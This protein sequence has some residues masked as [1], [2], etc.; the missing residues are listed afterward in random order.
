MNELIMKSC[1]REEKDRREDELPGPGGNLNLGSS[2]WQHKC[3]NHYTITHPS[4]KF[5]LLH[6]RKI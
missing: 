4:H 5:S 6:E 1:K 2:E 3:A